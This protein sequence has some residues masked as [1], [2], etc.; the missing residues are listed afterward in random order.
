VRK[1]RRWRCSRR[2][3]FPLGCTILY[4]G[5]GWPPVAP[6]CRT[7][8]HDCGARS[9]L[10]TQLLTGSDIPMCR[11]C[12]TR[13]RC[14]AHGSSTAPAAEATTVA[15]ATESAAVY[16]RCSRRCPLHGRSRPTA[17][18]LPLL[19]A[20]EVKL[21]AVGLSE[22]AYCVDGHHPGIE[23]IRRRQGSEPTS[24]RLGAQNHCCVRATVPACPSSSL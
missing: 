24:V 8:H 5:V 13:A 14:P 15:S 2:D 22:C 23:E 10:A 3:H 19:G 21:Q 1:S 16:G 6:R 9:G 17:R 12:G 20:T 18:L 7:W 11:G 4:Q